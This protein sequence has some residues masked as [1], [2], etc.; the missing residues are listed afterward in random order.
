MKKTILFLLLIIASANVFA[1]KGR[2]SIGISVEELG[3]LY[4]DCDDNYGGSVGITA[5]YQYGISNYLRVEPSFTYYV[6]PNR[7]TDNY[8]VRPQ[9][10]AGVSIHAFLTRPSKVRPYVIAGVSYIRGEER[11]DYHYD[12]DKTDF[13]DAKTGLGLDYRVAYNW[14]LQLEALFA[15]AFMAENI[16]IGLSYNF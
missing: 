1:Q 3:F 13:F 8:E 16:K 9:F 11:Y 6:Y 7:C 14:D 5:K 10:G 15:T 2:H 12:A 4:N